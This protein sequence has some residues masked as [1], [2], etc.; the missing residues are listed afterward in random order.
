M[1]DLVAA[2]LGL[3]HNELPQEC[4][5]MLVVSPIPIVSPVVCYIDFGLCLTVK[6][7]HFVP[8]N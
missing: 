4:A 3:K 8:Q 1:C 7:N 6:L 5:C 2:V